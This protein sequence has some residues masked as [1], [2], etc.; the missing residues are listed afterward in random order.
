MKSICFSLLLIFT[1]SATADTLRTNV[2]DITPQTASG[3]GSSVSIAGTIAAVGAP[4]GFSGINCRGTQFVQIYEKSTT[5]DPTA[6]IRQPE[7]SAHQGFGIS[8][9]LSGN[10]LAVGAPSGL[11]VL[12]TF[13]PPVGT[14]AGKVYLFTKSGSTWTHTRTITGTDPAFGIRVS[15]DGPTPSGNRFLA[16]GG[17]TAV[18]MN[19]K[20]SVYELASD[21]STVSSSVLPLPSGA[22][23]AGF[24][25]A[26][27]RNF[28]FD[29]EWLV[30]PSHKDDNIAIYRRVGTTW[31]LNQTLISNGSDQVA[32][33]RNG[34][35][36]AKGYGNLAEGGVGTYVHFYT[37][38]PDNQ[39]SLASSF[40]SPTVFVDANITNKQREH[41]G[42]E[43]SASGNFW[44]AATLEP[45]ITP[46]VWRSR[47]FLFQWNSSTG[48]SSYLGNWVGGTYLS[49]SE[50]TL[51]R[52]TRR[53]T[54]GAMCLTQDALW[55][56]SP[57]K[58]STGFA[59]NAG[60]AL[61]L[62][63]SG[64]V[65]SDTSVLSLTTTL[66]MTFTGQIQAFKFRDGTYGNYLLIGS[67]TDS[68]GNGATAANNS[69]AIY[70]LQRFADETEP[71]GERWSPAWKVKLPSATANDNFGQTI[72]ANNTLFAI[73]APGRSGKGQ[74]WTLDPSSLYIAG[75]TT[76]LL[77]GLPVPAYVG[78]GAR[79]GT[80]LA[81]DFAL[82][83]SLGRKLLAGAPEDSPSGS[84]SGRVLLYTLSTDGTTWTSEDVPRPAEVDSFDYFGFSV[85]W[86]NDSFATGIL[87]VI[88]SPL[89]EDDGSVYSIPIPQTL[90]SN[91]W[92]TRARY[93]AAV[94]V[95][96]FGYSLTNLNSGLGIGSYPLNLL[97][98]DIGR[99]GAYS[100]NLARPS[101]LHTPVSLPIPTTTLSSS[102]GAGFTVYGA[103][104]GDFIVGAPGDDT[105]GATNRGS[106]LIYNPPVGGGS[107]TL[108]QQIYGPLE[109]N[110][111][112]GSHI[113]ANN[114]GL[115]RSML[116]IS[117]TGI[118]AGNRSAGGIRLLRSSAYETWAESMGLD[119]I[120]FESSEDPDNDGS[121]NLLEFCMGTNPKLASS[122]PK[123]TPNSTGGRLGATYV[124]PTYNTSGVLPVWQVAPDPNLFGTPT[125]P[126]LTFGPD[127]T[128]SSAR[129]QQLTTANPRAFLRLRF[130]YFPP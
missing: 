6:S 62:N 26:W 53:L 128:P 34:F 93:T 83:N 74:V 27:A 3:L 119:S 100:L 90:N 126:T 58:G 91:T 121:T 111:A 56:T 81:F 66:P 60:N 122:S 103:N 24:Y 92:G 109:T 37:K 52:N 7:V 94:P 42:L 57:A 76:P 17:G 13:E 82:F 123:L 12:Q 117:G 19:P 45:T 14:P 118:R 73:G 55:L 47:V 115:N 84:F 106:V 71:S 8:V 35:I 72:A 40:R 65:W 2:A 31:S 88:G 95:G 124:P 30:C 120:D 36:L 96:A 50:S 51:F 112:F 86:G 25:A 41:F 39:F 9:S 102:A 98:G 68:D 77:T 33:S 21:L 87:A 48:N 11:S 61:I 54:P 116:V 10:V 105:G 125:F 4:E 28:S 18:P 38:G 69:G 70:L 101:S 63:R 67:P 49:S 127:S 80:S 107:W 43:L 44:A 46:T 1:V 16:V 64:S 113:T 29:G 104:N 129:I 32:V 15:F 59:N 5:W 97:G 79:L 85:A 108:A 20:I 22:S 89:D 130:S 114:N 99:G 78:A 75:N 23:V 110:A